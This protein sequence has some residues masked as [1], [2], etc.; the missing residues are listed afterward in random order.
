MMMLYMIE[1]L[2]LS[3]EKI[4]KFQVVLAVPDIINRNQTLGLVDVLLKQL[5]FR[6]IYLH[7]E[8]ILSA[9]GGG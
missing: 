9:I 5:Q 7:K 4:R 6:A 3:L 1:K 8:S 2:K